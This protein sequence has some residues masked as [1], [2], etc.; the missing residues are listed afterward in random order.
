M[1]TVD[2]LALLSRLAMAILYFILF[3]YFFGENKKS[4]KMGRP[5]AFFKG[6]LVLFLILVFFHLIYGS[7]ELYS[8]V[9]T[10][11]IDLTAKFPWYVQ[12]SGW[13]DNLSYQIKPLFL[14]FYFYPAGRLNK[15]S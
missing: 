1:Q 9:A 10:N 13:L 8:S 4:K 14:I 7:I 2:I 15:V 12:G 3:V 6:N 5:N 11:P